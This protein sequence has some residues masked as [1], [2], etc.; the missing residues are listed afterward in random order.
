MNSQCGS[1]KGTEWFVN[2]S[3]HNESPTQMLKAFDIK[4]EPNPPRF[5]ARVPHTTIHS[6]KICP[7]C[8]IR[9]KLHGLTSKRN[10]TDLQELL[11]HVNLIK[12]STEATQNLVPDVHPRDSY[13]ISE[14]STVAHKL[15]Q[16]AQG[17][18]LSPYKQANHFHT[19]LPTYQLG[20]NKLLN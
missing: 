7:T 3:P 6:I 10:L 12:W 14:R 16:F 11:C 19:T 4:Q 2:C 9:I 18:F 20:A 15:L 8:S 17:S 13:L 1:R 5:V